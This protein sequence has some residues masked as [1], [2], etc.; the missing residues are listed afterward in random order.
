MKDGNDYF[1]IANDVFKIE[2]E[3]IVALG[4]KLNNNFHKVIETIHNC[5]GRVIVCG[6]GKPGII[7]RKIQATLASIGAPSLSLHPAEAVHGDLGMVTKNDVVLTLSSSGET[8]EML[9]LIPIVKKIGATMIS[10][11][12]NPDSTLAKHSDLVLDVG[13]KEEA[14]PLGLAPTASTTALL[15]MGDAI[16][17]ALI[18]RKQLKPEEFALYHPG[19][20]L[21]KKLLKVRDVM[22]TGEANPI[23]RENL[24]LKEVLLFIT[25]ARA[26]AAAVVDK[27][28]KLV[29]IFT[30][31]DLRRAI[32][33]Q[34]DVSAQSISDFMI[35]NPIT[36][37]PDKLVMEAVRIMGGENPK[38][39]KLD[40]LPVV[41]E[42]HRPIGMLDV[43]DLIGI[44]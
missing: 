41:D 1:K 27:K 8:E 25:R 38:K 39:R 18:K 36:I 16:A 20:S 40:E 26:G 24:K 30:D 14:C 6:M 17:V 7:G 43:V 21:G 4:K 23:V 11:T 37:N 9:K 22:R 28:G 13:V 3:A 31:G 44:S 2:A 33:K 42:K 15:A 32:E 12:G 35:P 10:M 29:G 34:S 19:G 5:T